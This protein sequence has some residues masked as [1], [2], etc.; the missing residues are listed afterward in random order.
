M[1][2]FIAHFYTLGS[3]KS[4]FLLSSRA[5]KRL[6][7]FVKKK[8]LLVIDFFYPLFK[9]IMPLQTFR[10]AV[11]GGSNLL[12]NILIYFV[13]FQFILR[14]QI[15]HLPFISISAEIA[16][17]I[18]AFLVTFPIGFYLS[19]YVVFPGSDLERRVQLF[20][21]FVIVLI[22]I[23]LNYFLLSLFVR[24]FHWY[25]TPSYVLDCVLVTSFSYFS[26]KYFSFQSKK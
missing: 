18:I 3:I 4:F 11:C 14:K 13:S 5:M 8:I 1:T 7:L 20:R 9:S 19:M 10:Y 22:C 21:Y 2:Q 15:V 6:H 12:S 17:Y 24:V 25:P 26:H 16:A 23:L